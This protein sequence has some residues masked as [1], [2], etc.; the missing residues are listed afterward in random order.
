MQKPKHLLSR[1]FFSFGS[2]LVIFAV[3]L[4][5]TG[6]AFTTTALASICEQNECVPGGTIRSG[7][8]C[9]ACTNW[10][11]TC[12]DTVTV[13]FFCDACVL[14]EVNCGPTET[15]CDVSGSCTV[16][17]KDKYCGVSSCHVLSYMTDLDHCTGV[18]TITCP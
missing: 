2:S 3:Y 17:Y 7:V 11:G 8:Q 9:E 10:S 14:I 1:T 13:P 16:T 18:T 4:L 12:C 6:G 15:N 5:A